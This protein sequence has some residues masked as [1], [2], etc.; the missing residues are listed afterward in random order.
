MA[1]C[2]AFWEE[3]VSRI[4]SKPS[5]FRVAPISSASFAGLASFISSA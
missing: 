4:T 3:S 5:R 2:M 1:R